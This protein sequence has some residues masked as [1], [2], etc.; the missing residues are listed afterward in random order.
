[1]TTIENTDLRLFVWFDRICNDNTNLCQIWKIGCEIVLDDPLCILFCLYSRITITRENVIYFLT[2]GVRR[3]RCDTVD[4]TRRKLHILPYPI[5][6]FVL[7]CLV[8]VC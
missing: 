7:I 5:C 2:K 6:E 1:M 8:E 4:H 3:T